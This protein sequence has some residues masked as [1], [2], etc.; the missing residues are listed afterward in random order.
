M[1]FVGV[2]E[3]SVGGKRSN[4][5]ERSNKPLHITNRDKRHPKG[6]PRWKCFLKREKK[7]ERR[8]K[9]TWGGER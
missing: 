9:E 1:V 7:E 3:E 8:E 4:K 5:R 6:H 2:G